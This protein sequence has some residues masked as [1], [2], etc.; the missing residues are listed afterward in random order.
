MLT[1]MGKRF[2]F[3]LFLLILFQ[4]LLFAQMMIKGRVVSA[5]QKAPLAGVSVFLSNTS[6]GTTSNSAGEFQM[7][8]PAAKYDLIASSVGYETHAQTITSENVSEILI[9]LRPKAQ[10]LDEVVVGAFE[11]NGWNTWGK[12]FIENFIGTTEWAEDCVIKNT[13][14]IKFRRDK[15]KNTISAIAFDRLIIE[16]KSLGY[17]ISYQLEGFEYNFNTTY[18]SFMGYPLITPMT[19]NAARERRWKTRR[20]DVYYGSMMDFMRALYRNKITEAGFEVRRLAKSPNVEKQRVRE[21]YRNRALIMKTNLL[22][23]YD[24]VGDSTEYYE[25]ILSQ[26]DQILTF[27]PY[28]ITGDSIAYGIDSVTAALEFPDFLH[29]TYK[30][31]KPPQKY[32]I[33]SPQNTKMMSELTFV[34]E[35]PLEVQSN[36]N[37]FPPLKLVSAGYWAWSEKIGSLLPFNYKPSEKR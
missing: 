28:L 26:T 10:V 32:R 34:T 16:N 19:G 36:G 14:V 17:I 27:S 6:F 33:R 15:K 7:S 21:I 2:Y 23:K 5:D 1:G 25:K 12:F 13:D 8:A 24:P 3:V 11:K 37:Y 29:I 35:G 22:N 31:A 20:D 18:L 30:K 9:T 4:P